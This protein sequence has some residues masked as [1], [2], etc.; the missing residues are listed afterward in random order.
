MSCVRTGIM[1]MGPIPVSYPWAVSALAI[2]P[3]SP[4]LSF[5]LLFTHTRLWPARVVPG[6]TEVL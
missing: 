2:K 4:R 3:P 1:V 5:M 6:L